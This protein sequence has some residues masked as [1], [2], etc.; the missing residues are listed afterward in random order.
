MLDM[1]R[2]FHVVIQQDEDGMYIGKVP[3]LKGCVSQGKTIPELMKNMKEAI[4]LCLDIQ[5]EDKTK[6]VG[7]KE[8]EIA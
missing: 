3:E 1:S 2:K 7:V 8:I 4:E 6:F 5:Q